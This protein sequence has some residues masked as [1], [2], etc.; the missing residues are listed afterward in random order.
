M[1]DK[2][3]ILNNK[4]N[5]L[6]SRICVFLSVDYVIEY[7]NLFYSNCLFESSLFLK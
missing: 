3:M 2:S 7:M 6:N 5:F 1:N 4:F